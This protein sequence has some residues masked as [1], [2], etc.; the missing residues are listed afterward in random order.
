MKM[1]SLF[2][3]LFGFLSACGQ[4]NG[5]NSEMTEMQKEY[6]RHKQYFEESEIAHFPKFLHSEVNSIESNLI[7]EN[8]NVG[9]LLFEFEINESLLDSIITSTEK[10]N[11]IRKYHSNDS[12][13]LYIIPRSDDFTNPRHLSSNVDYSNQLPVADLN[14]YLRESEY[15]SNYINNDFD[16]YVLEAKAEKLSKYAELPPNMNMSEKW[17]NG[18]SKGISIS[19][20]GKIV[21]YWT[22]IW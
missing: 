12:G 4:Q 21:V 13:L 5:N 19:K 2:I 3:F 18:F 14:F 17:R 11:V 6:D 20:K 15:F 8:N 1:Y 10:M 22:I 7:F 9:F 16:I